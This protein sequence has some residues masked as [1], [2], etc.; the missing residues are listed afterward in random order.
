METLKIIGIILII[1]GVV[2][3]GFYHWIRWSLIDIIETEEPLKRLDI[4]KLNGTLDFEKLN[5]SILN[6]EINDLKIVQLNSRLKK[7]FKFMCAVFVSIILWFV[8][9]YLILRWR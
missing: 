7:C 3:N 9:K 5:T 1:V 2:S 4:F 8:F 6:N